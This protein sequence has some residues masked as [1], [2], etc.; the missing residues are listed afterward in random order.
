MLGLMWR[1]LFSVTG[2]SKVRH[3]GGFCSA[4]LVRSPILESVIGLVSDRVL[5]DFVRGM[6]FC[7]TFIGKHIYSNKQAK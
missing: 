7:E 1:A 3:I 2:I 4:H 6:R 5:N